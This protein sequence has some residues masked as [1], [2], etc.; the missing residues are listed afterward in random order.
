VKPLRFV[1]APGTIIT[2]IGRPVL[3]QLTVFGVP[4]GS[5]T[6][7]VPAEP[8]SSTTTVP[9]WASTIGSGGWSAW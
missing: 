3:R 4:A 6:V 5:R 2:R 9:L 1:R 7:K 8:G